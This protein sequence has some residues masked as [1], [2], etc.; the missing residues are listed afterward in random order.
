MKTPES[1][2][3]YCIISQPIQYFE[4]SEIFCVSN[5]HVFQSTK[6]HLRKKDI[7]ELCLYLIGL[8]RI[9]L[10][11]SELL[12]TT[13]CSYPQNNLTFSSYIE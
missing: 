12:I 9:V 8:L 10:V 1:Y 3:L 11:R 13:L 4:L 6:D 7:T 5:I 2:I